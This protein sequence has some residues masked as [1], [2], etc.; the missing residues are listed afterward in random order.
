MSAARPS[1]RPG[2]SDEMDLGGRVD[3][4]RTFGRTLD[5]RVGGCGAPRA[6]CYHHGVF[7]NVHTYARI[8]VEIAERTRRKAVT[9][10]GTHR[11]RCGNSRPSMGAMLDVDNS[12]ELWFKFPRAASGSSNPFAS[13]PGCHLGKYEK[14]HP[15][16]CGLGGA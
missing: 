9:I 2:L 6:R 1:E 8:A 5:I 15:V 4:L 14:P 10:Q 11:S 13:R 12:P 7:A 16:N 3:Q